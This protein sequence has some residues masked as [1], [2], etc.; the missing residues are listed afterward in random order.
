MNNEPKNSRGK[1]L[2]VDDDISN[3]RVLSA[4]LEDDYEVSVATDGQDALNSVAQLNPDVILLDWMMP[5]LTGLEVCKQLQQN[6]DTHSIPII[7]ITAKDD[8]EVESLRAGA[9]DYI[10]KPI[11]AEIVKARVKTHYQNYLYIQYLESMAAL[12]HEHQK[13]NK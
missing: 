1:V 7:F 4:L 6:K 9:V 8:G 10:T 5:G 13:I 2:V 3:L 11:N 12:K